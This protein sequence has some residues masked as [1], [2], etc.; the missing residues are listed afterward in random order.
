MRD[1]SMF[2]T[3]VI[4]LGLAWIALGACRGQEATKPPPP[5]PAVAPAPAEP[6]PPAPPAAGTPAAIEALLEDPH[7]FPYWTTWGEEQGLPHH[8]VFAV[9]VDGPRVIVGTEAGAAILDRASGAW[10]ALPVESAPGANDGLAYRVVTSV[11]VDEDGHVWFGTLKGLSAWDGERFENHRMPEGQA[12]AAPAPTG[13]VNNVVYSVAHHG[14]E[15]WAAT[16]D[17]TSQFNKKTRAWKT[18][19]LNNAPMEETWC[20]GIAASPNKVWLAAWGSGL[21]EYTVDA[22]TWQAYHDPDGSFTVDLFRN[23]GMLS[24]MSTSVSYGGG[25]VWVASYFGVARY[26]GKAWRDWDQDHGLPSNFLNFVKARP[27]SGWVATDKGLAGFA[28]E[29]WIT[30][31]RVEEGDQV[32]GT[33]TIANADGREGHVYKT[34]GAIPHPFVWGID[35]D[36]DGAIWIATSDGLG[37]GTRTRPTDG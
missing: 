29:R 1:R 25:A 6:A 5:A 8:M 20:Y 33:I 23:D 7:V 30:Y 3:H 27:D 2:R 19:Y 4:L 21:M 26:D 13:L 15:I 31:G 37:R 28:G 36:P 17:G 12:P 32:H 18:W 34:P 22:G 16:T 14:D 24:Q 10:R 35:F 9:K 11:D